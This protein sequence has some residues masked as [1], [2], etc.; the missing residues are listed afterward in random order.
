MAGRQRAF[1]GWSSLPANTRGIV[2]MCA[3]A[4]CYAALYV[5]LRQLT[6]GYSPLELIFLRAA[7]C[8]L[9]MLPWLARSGFG[10]L[11][12]RRLPLHVL[13][14]AATYVAGVLW[15]YGLAHLP[16]ADV[17]ALNF[18]SPL[19]VVTIAMLFLGDRS[20]LH[21][22]LVLGVGFAGTLI[23]LRPGITVVSFAAL[24]TLG[25]ACMFAV[26]HSITKLMASTEHPN[27]NVFYLYGLQSLLA[28]VP[29]ALV[30][31]T[32]GAADFGWIVAVS[33]CTLG[34][35][36][37]IVRSLTTSPASLVMPFNFLQLPLVAI[38]GL[39]VYGEVAS[40]WTWI[41]AAVIFAATYD[42][43]RR[44]G[45]ARRAHGR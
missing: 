25:G 5:T 4:A 19:F 15:V 9:F 6:A 26:S 1:P 8:T 40:I 45:R 38:A 29:A 14:M 39:I 10:A 13:R 7:F 44:E 23:I 24:V 12:T 11:R 37:C 16:M 21:R 2:W 28:L 41:G 33:L 3:A 35:Q 27:L 32:P 22:W 17:N 31:R 30:W 43:A 34:A 18:T 20:S 36:Q 42:L